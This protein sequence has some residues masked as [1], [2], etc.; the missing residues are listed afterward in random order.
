M[1]KLNH[2][3]LIRRAHGALFGVAIGDAMGAIVGSLAGA[4]SGRD[5]I[6]PE[7]IA[8]VQVSAGKRIG[9]VAGTD[10]EHVAAELVRR[11]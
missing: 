2:A 8:R 9:F 4:Y 11:S 7:W 10:V 3:D 5:S 6:P 1:S